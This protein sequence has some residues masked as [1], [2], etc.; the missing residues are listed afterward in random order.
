MVTKP[1]GVPRMCH[2]VLSLSSFWLFLLEIDKDLAAK[3]RSGGCP[4]CGG[5]LDSADYR[6]KPRGP[7]VDLPPGC[8]KRLS[9][10]CASDGCR[11][12]KT[13]P[14][15]RF[16]GRKVYLAGVVALVTAMRQG[17]TPWGMKKL[18]NLFG[19]DR[20]SVERWA[21][22]W[23]E[24]FPRSDFWREKKASAFS[25]PPR[26]EELPLRLL[27]EFRSPKKC[28]GL[29]PLLEFLSPVTTPVEYLSMIHGD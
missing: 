14:S 2:G 20:R 24:H 17:A 3:D 21:E 19:V 12:R 13:P 16:L 4:H 28:G 18:R 8:E 23:T 29:A 25:S 26:D 10:C 7:L 5:R 22:F 9:F 11:R 1:F 15:A 6:R 27:G